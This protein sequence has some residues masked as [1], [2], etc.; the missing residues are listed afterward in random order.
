LKSFPERFDA[1]VVGSSGGIGSQIA[2]LLAERAKCRS[3]SLLSRT[4][5]ESIDL[6][7]ETS[8]AR[9]ADTFAAQQRQF[10]LIFDATGVL[11]V[12]GQGPEKSLRDLDSDSMAQAFAVNAI[13]PAL[14]FK[15][16]SRL[17]TREGKSAFA[18]LSARVG[19]IG[20]N[21]L[22]S[23]YSYRA[24]KAA[25]NQIVR[26]AA[27]EIARTRPQAV[28]LALHPGTVETALT[29]D[30]ARGRYTH[31]PGDAARKLLTVIDEASPHHTGQFL[32]YDGSVIPW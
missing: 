6:T 2:R 10:G 32:A 18:T 31:S 23:W 14:L 21:H 3:V 27:I 9:A 29:K 28:C 24:S 30:Y 11:A 17:L 19:S 25:L 16:F 12:N 7:D 26:T 20:D 8:I 15:H 1:L 22:G 4:S 13:G 5:S